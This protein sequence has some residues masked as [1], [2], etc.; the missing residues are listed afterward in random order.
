MYRN[1]LFIL[2]AL[3]LALSSPLSAAQDA[4][5]VSISAGSLH[6]ALQQYSQQTGVEIFVRDSLVEGLSAQALKRSDNPRQ[7]LE[8]L[9]SGTQLEAVWQSD[10]AVVIKSKTAVTQA[11]PLANTGNDQHIE[12]VQVTGT[13]LNADLSMEARQVTVIERQEI[14]TL[15]LGSRSVAEML[16]KVVPGMSPA[17]QTMTNWGLTL[18]G[19][20]MLVLLD[21]VPLNTN[22]NVSRDLA[23][24][25]PDVVDRIEV[26]RGGNAI[27]GSGATG[28]V[29]AIT[30]RKG[31]DMPTSTKFA[32][33][34]PLSTLDSDGLGGQ[35]FQT[36]GFSGES[37]DLSI[38]AGY[39]QVGGYFDAE[40]DRI[41]PEMSQGDVMD[42]GVVDL[43]ANLG[44]DVSEQRR[45]AFGV[46]YK[47]IKQDTEYAPD[48]SVN[49]F[50]AGTVKAKGVQ[51]LQ[52]DKQNQVKNLI[53]NLSYSDTSF[54][55]GDINSQLY[56]RDYHTRFNPFSTGF[57]NEAGERIPRSAQTYLDAEVFG[58][59]LSITNL[60]TDTSSLLWGLDYH[61]DK[62][63]NRATIYDAE[64]A[65]QLKYQEIDDR[66]WMPS[67]RTEN[68]G[69][70]AQLRHEFNADWSADAGARYEFIDISWDSFVPV[71][72]SEYQNP[73]QVAGSSLNSNGLVLNAGV[74][75]R[76]FDNHELYL[77]F[78]QGFEQPDVSLMLRKQA[79]GFTAFSDALEPVKTDNYEMGWRGD[80]VATQAELALFYSYSKFGKATAEGLLEK[81][82]RSPERIYGVEAVI[83]QE[84]NEQW[85]AGASFSWIKGEVQ[86]ASSGQYQQMDGWRIP[87][88]K[89][90]GFVSYNPNEHWQN[91]LQL[92]YSAS[93][94]YRING[95]TG[96]GRREVD[97][98]WS[99][100]LVSQFDLGPG[101]LDLGIENLF[102][103]SYYPLYSQLLR[104]NANTSHVPARGINATLAYTLYW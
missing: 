80:W 12:K 34:A 20:N 79:P 43:G 87:P 56:Y 70:F 27:Y 96:F 37:I 42:S 36:A 95:K 51:G 23:N 97:S 59:R 24:L 3:T 66:L 47:G 17:S 64:Q 41:A 63:E 67:V 94:D 57:K 18:R 19:R 88:V 90:T 92:F 53:L 6:Q 84:I 74:V 7:A 91:R 82:N 81:A 69:L 29:I 46:T 11:M 10:D 75:Y 39:Q 50:P 22:R 102:N 25:S 28:G 21:G 83:N 76:G 13:R 32:M 45:L 93:K 14:E 61:N 89:V 44:W 65:K 4:A 68:T 100:D 60:L 77:A 8:K 33:S 78:N 35:I 9:L 38:Y 58:G 52:L 5:S 16:S 30:T 73:G 62:S 1:K 99:A 55:W 86:P 101:R 40:G 31:A 49:Q 72:L 15:S 98:Y 104:N 103:N 48:M 54:N 2:S 26:V 71:S 85:G